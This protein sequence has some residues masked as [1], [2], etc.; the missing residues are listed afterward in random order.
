VLTVGSANRLA[1]LLDPQIQPALVTKKAD[2]KLAA[3][4][5]K[6]FYIPGSLLSARIDTRQ[7][8]AYGMTPTV[9]IFFDESQ[10]FT[11]SGT[12]AKRVAWFEGKAPLRSGWAVGQGK[13]DGTVA[14]ADVDLGKGKLFAMGP[15]VT[16][17]AQ[18]YATFKLLFNGLLYGPSVAATR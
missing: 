12:G 14:V 13:L 15:E 16:Q 4:D 3:L 1:T 5:K 10:P 6:Q 18:P 7:P 9:D 11:L 8:L 2:G 17:R